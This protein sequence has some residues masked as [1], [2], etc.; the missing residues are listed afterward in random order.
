MKYPSQY[1]TERGVVGVVL[2]GESILV[3]NS[4][5]NGIR[6]PSSPL[7]DACPVLALVEELFCSMERGGMTEECTVVIVH[8]KCRSGGETVTSDGWI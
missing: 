4:Y 8:T 6:V 2:C 5:T 1:S 7:I 3:G